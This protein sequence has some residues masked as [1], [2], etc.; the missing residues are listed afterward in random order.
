[1]INGIDRLKNN[2]Q[3][4]YTRAKNLDSLM[5]NY[6][7]YFQEK[8][9]DRKLN[10]KLTFDNFTR[11][12]ESLIVQRIVNYKLFETMQMR[13][14]YLTMWSNNIKIINE[15]RHIIGFAWNFL[16]DFLRRRFKWF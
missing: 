16:D 4:I 11:H 12:W 9:K 2:W 10:S 14:K 5:I 7:H 1:M 6:F 3:E 8:F 15:V 13:Q